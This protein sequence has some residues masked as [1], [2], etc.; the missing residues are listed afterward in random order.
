MRVCEIEI[1]GKQ[2]PICF[3]T[4]VAIACQERAGSPEK[5]LNKIA[6]EDIQEIFWLLTQMIAAGCGY[7]KMNGEETPTPIGYE[8]LVDIVGVDDYP[9]MFTAIS[10]AIQKDT[11]RTVKTKPAKT[12]KNAVARQEK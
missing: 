12:A 8:E 3:S 10:N 1:D 4:R 2:Y 5:V 11:T 6:S 9:S 7:K